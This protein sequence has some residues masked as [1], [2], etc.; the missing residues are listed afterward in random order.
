[1]GPPAGRRAAVRGRPLADPAL[2][3]Q[4]RL[5]LADCALIAR[6]V[7]EEVSAVWQEQHEEE[8][9]AVSEK[10]I[11]LLNEQPY[12]SRKCTRPSNFP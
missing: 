1:M 9:I 11:G 4:P 10:M 6:I 2:G 7:K 3:P 12:I 8:Q 5:T